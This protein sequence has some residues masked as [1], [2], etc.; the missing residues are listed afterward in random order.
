M[1]GSPHILII[2]DAQ[3]R[4][5]MRMAAAAAAMGCTITVRPVDKGTADPPPD[6]GGTIY[7]DDPI[8]TVTEPVVESPRARSH[9]GQ[10]FYEG[11]RRKRWG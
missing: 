2:G 4:H 10:G 8:A 3:S 6:C 9:A 11:R 5:V 7:I 1:T